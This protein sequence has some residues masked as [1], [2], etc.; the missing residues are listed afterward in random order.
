MGDSEKEEKVLNDSGVPFHLELHWYVFLK[1]L[2]HPL[3]YVFLKLLWPKTQGLFWG[4]R[5]KGHTLDKNQLYAH[6]HK[7]VLYSWRVLHNFPRELRGYFLCWHS[8]ERLLLNLRFTHFSLWASLV[9]QMVK[10]LPEMQETWVCFMGWEDPLEEGIA[11]HSTILTW[12]IPCTKEQA[13]VHGV[14]KSR[15]RLSN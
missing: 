9:A 12:R 2:W 6:F 5:S 13:I 11:T 4:R 10:N 7:P 8:V 14:A 1:L 3:K 15:T